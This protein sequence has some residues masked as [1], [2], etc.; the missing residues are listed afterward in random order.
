[1]SDSE[2]KDNDEYEIAREKDYYDVLGLTQS[3][4]P[5]EIKQAF[6]ALAQKHHP[7]LAKNESDNDEM[8]I[9]ISEAYDTLR[10]PDKRN[11][12]NKELGY[13]HFESVDLHGVGDP[14]IEPSSGETGNFLKTPIFEER[15]TAADT[16]N[17]IEEFGEGLGLKV[18]Q[19]AALSEDQ[20]DDEEQGPEIEAWGERPEEPTKP[21][22]FKERLFGKISNHVRR[23][24]LKETLKERMT[25]E[26]DRENFKKI[27]KPTKPLTAAEVAKKREEETSNNG[28]VLREE[29]IY[30]FQISKLE[31]ITGTTRRLALQSSGEEPRINEVQIP[32]GIKN[33]QV[34]EVAWGWERAKIQV[35]IVRDPLFDVVGRDFLLRLPVTLEE[36]IEGGVFTVPTME[37]PSRVTLPA[38]TDPVSGFIIPEVG[39]QI[40][41][42]FPRGNLII[43]PRIVPPKN[44]SATFDAASNAF[45]KA[46][47][48]DVRSGEF[49]NTEGKHFS[50]E[51][52]H[53]MVD[54]PITFGESFKGV[55]LTINSPCGELTFDVNG[56]WN[57]SEEIRLVGAGKESLSGGRGDVF[58]Y[59]YVVLPEPVNPALKAAANAISQHHMS[60]VRKNV[61][62]KIGS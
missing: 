17:K 18:S 62:K 45:E 24:E 26:P 7:D 12:Y 56:P 60:P 3:A 39:L 52:N 23:K 9:A 29:R 53:L 36:A 10:D 1:M 41:P 2:N 16:Y 11:E 8:F 6:R 33:G 21:L 48:K 31:S 15:V 61:P 38:Q 25:D 19:R 30:P 20:E 13:G 44:S 34:M 55:S 4:S 35:S 59:P 43:S 54:L 22:S 49:K 28:S 32:G 51:G 58:I 37:G 27:V 46:Y 14:T 50:W 47:S 57:P 5:E 40:D 42:S